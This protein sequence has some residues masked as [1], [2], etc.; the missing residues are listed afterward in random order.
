MKKGM[1]LVEVLVALLLCMIVAFVVIQMISGEH[2]NYTKT[3]EKIRIQSDAREAMR[4]MEEEIKNIGYRI[5]MNI[6]SS[7]VLSASACSEVIYT[8]TQAAFSTPATSQVQFRFYNPMETSTLDCSADLWTIGYSLGSD[9]VLTRTTKKGVSGTES[10]VPFLENVSEFKVTYGVYVDD[11]PV[12]SGSD[13]N[14]DSDFDSDEAI[15]AVNAASS[16]KPFSISNWPADNEV[17]MLKKA[18]S[19]DT[20]GTYRVNFAADA[21]DQFM[22]AT[23]GYESLVFGLFFTDGTQ[24]PGTS[25]VR[26]KPGKGG[27]ARVIQFDFSPSILSADLSKVIYFGFKSKMKLAGSEVSKV[28]NI[29]G[30]K[31]TKLNSG[32]YKST[33]LDESHTTASDWSRVKAVRI[34]LS[35]VSSKN[36][37][38]KLDRIIPVVNNA[39]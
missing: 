3:R 11:E 38:V 32:I 14:L 19:I 26:F 24:V 12:I 34:Q 2:A 22:D 10:S 1:T 16:N 31:C 21:S 27:I 9:K 6:N 5:S 25:T 29:S 8:A 4:L 35:A 30:L 36:E 17:V 23:I 33:W 20:N 37:S 7:K 15:V 39:D 18:L 13:I 28:L